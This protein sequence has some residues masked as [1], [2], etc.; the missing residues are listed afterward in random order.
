MMIDSAELSSTLNHHSRRLRWA[1]IAFAILTSGCNATRPSAPRQSLHWPTGLAEPPDVELAP[2]RELEPLT[3]FRWAQILE[4]ERKFFQAAHWYNRAIR[5]NPDFIQAYNRL[6]LVY[7]RMKE[8]GKAEQAFELAI[9]RNPTLAFLR[10]NLGFSYLLD[11]R[12]SKAEQ[13]FREALKLKPKFTRAQVNLALALGQLRR[14]DEAHDSLSAVLTPVQANYNMGLIHQFNAEPI[15]ASRWHRRALAIDSD[16]KPA[17]RQLKRLSAGLAPDEYSDEVPG[18]ESKAAPKMVPTQEGRKPRMTAKVQESTRVAAPVVQPLPTPELTVDSRSREPDHA[19][20]VSSRAATGEK[21]LSIAERQEKEVEIPPTSAAPPPIDLR[22]P[23]DGI[24]PA[25]MSGQGSAQRSPSAM[26]A[27]SPRMQADPPPVSSEGPPPI[28]IEAKSKNRLPSPVM[29]PS[30]GGT[31]AN[32]ADG[33]SKSKSLG[34]KTSF[35]Q[36]LIIEGGFERHAPSAGD[37]A[38]E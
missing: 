28:R 5:K 3:M 35:V 34:R 13:Q 19:A 17:A 15:L 11:R 2:T 21:P 6:G 12:S 10:N 29:L 24:S 33:A 27:E 18:P 32:E 37:I 30:P 1:V 23:G 9:Q 16:F 36:H 8:L 4:K 7:I 25:G 20:N 14:Y 38:A 22:S 26:A 31:S